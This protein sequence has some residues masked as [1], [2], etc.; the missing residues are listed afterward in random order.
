VT[1]LGNTQPTSTG[2][3]T[4]TQYAALDHAVIRR[5]VDESYRATPHLQARDLHQI[6]GLILVSAPTCQLDAPVRDHVNKQLLLFYYVIR[7]NWATALEFLSLLLETK[8]Q[9]ELGLPAPAVRRPP[10]RPFPRG[11]GRGQTPAR[12]APG[13]G[14]AAH[15]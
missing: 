7:T 3:L 6:R 1:A 15:W 14:G 2:K 8:A 10:S 11:R 4:Q 5:F 13:G 12:G 9:N